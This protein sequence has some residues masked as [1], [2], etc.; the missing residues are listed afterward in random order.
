LVM[1]MIALWYLKGPKLLGVLLAFAFLC[2]G[3]R[4]GWIALLGGAVIPFLDMPREKRKT[5]ISLLGVLFIIGIVLQLPR[6]IDRLDPRYI[7]N[8]QRLSMIKGVAHAFL[9]HPIFGH[10]AWTFPIIGQRYLIWP[11]WELHPHSFPLRVLFE[12]GLIGALAWG[13]FFWLVGRGREHRAPTAIFLTIAAGSL[14][15]DLLWIP[16]FSAIFFLCAGGILCAGPWRVPKAVLAA[17]GIIA[18]FG[19]LVHEHVRTFPFRPISHLIDEAITNNTVPDYRGWQEDPWALRIAGYDSGDPAFFER[20]LA[21]DPNMIFGPHL[22]DLGRFDQARKI[23]PV[24]TAWHLRET[25][26]PSP[27]PIDWHYG[28]ESPHATSRTI[29]WGDPKDWRHYRDSGAVLLAAGDTERARPLFQTA[30][31]LAQ[32]QYGTDPILCRLAAE[33]MPENREQLLELAKRREH[34]A[35]PYAIF[36]PLIYRHSVRS[37]GE[38]SVWWSQ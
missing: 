36:A 11:K 37:S 33:V 25:S 18:A 8:S 28:I 21:R 5:A 9:E 23:A 15:D 31:F 29:A 20:A 7:T 14:T 34:P 22:L 35:Y 6:F 13:A 17:I 19:P 30:F 2:T 32:K 26:A 12:S 10:G 3:S 1:G 24:L 16:L 27:T 4:T 38:N